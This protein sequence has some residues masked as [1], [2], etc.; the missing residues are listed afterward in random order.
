MRL[1]RR[2]ASPTARPGT[3]RPIAAAVIRDGDR[4]LVWEEDDGSSYIARRRGL[5]E[6]RGP[7]RLV[8]DGLL[9]LIQ[10]A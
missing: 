4:L 8:P 5:D 9:D 10:G 1:R 2:G 7:A 3:I 6:L